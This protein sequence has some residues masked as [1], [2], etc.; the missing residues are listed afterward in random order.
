MFDFLIDLFGVSAAKIDIDKVLRKESIM[1]PR[2]KK[3]DGWDSDSG[4]EEEEKKQEES[5][6]EK[7]IKEDQIKQ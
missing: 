1:V 7:K 6:D 5:A 2:K 4:P 3:K